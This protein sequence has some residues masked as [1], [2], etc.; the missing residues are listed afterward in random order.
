MAMYTSVCMDFIGGFGER[1]L[2]TEPETKITCTVLSLIKSWKPNSDSILWTSIK[3][4]ALFQ[5]LKMSAI[6][7]SMYLTAKGKVQQYM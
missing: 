7:I 6:T 4:I 3:N 1:L 5:I 2:K